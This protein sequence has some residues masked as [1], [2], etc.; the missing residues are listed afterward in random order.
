MSQTTSQRPLWVLVLGL[1]LVAG[2]TVYSQSKPKPK[3]KDKKPPSESQV[4]T[5]DVQAEKAKIEYVN[6]LLTV[7]QGYEDAGL[8]TKSK[9]TLE[10]VLTVVPDFEPARL[11]LKALEDAV[12]E[13]NT[14]D[15]EVEAGNAW[16]TSGLIVFKDKP[17]RIIADG[18]LRVILNETVDAK[19]LPAGDPASSLVS[20]I[21]IGGLMGL[22]NDPRANPR[23]Q[24]VD[25]FFVGNELELRP[26]NDGLLFLKLNLP[27]NTQ[28]K[29]KIRIKI[30][31]N[32]KK[33][34]G[35]GN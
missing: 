29:G 19:G 17:L 2:G 10:S 15:V 16:I 4:R 23:D 18:T 3:D 8:T 21:P 30:S 25:P 33:L 27:P 32:A 34:P 6:G 7:A 5:L 14:F 22:V 9:E 1:F 26:K 24:K 28:S 35:G 13:E 12:F 20:N 11:K 31:G